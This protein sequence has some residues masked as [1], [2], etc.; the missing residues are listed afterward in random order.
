MNEKVKLNKKQEV[1]QEEPV[2]QPTPEF[3]APPVSAIPTEPATWQTTVNSAPKSTSTFPTNAVQLPS[4]GLL[5]PFDSPLRQGYVE[6]K[7]M[8]AKEENIL[9]TESYINQGIV[10]DKFLESMIV[11]PKFDFNQLL[12]GD[13][14]ALIVA[15]RI[16]GHGEIY[17]IE[18][19]TPSGKKQKVD[20]DLNQLEHKE[21]PEGLFTDGQNR[22]NYSFE[23]RFGCYD[24]TFKLLTGADNRDIEAS[25]KKFKKAGAADKQV[26][27]RLEHIILS[28]NGN[29]DP[30]FIKLF[31]ENEFLSK[32][33][34]T[35]RDYV[36][37]ITPGVNFEI[38]VVDEETGDS[39]RSNLTLGPDFFWPD[40]RV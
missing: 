32:D 2:Y 10:I 29:S 26:T 1:V 25:L 6:M 3:I 8:T 39:F 24:L 13:K 36:A 35:F 15:S 14:D 7:F 34:R 40:L 20:V 4:K 30:M 27:T 5:Y 12:S 22:F 28:V 37:S 11:A 16:Y 31:V 23:N 38:E 17:N 9:T 21:L 19:T 33:Y 18:V